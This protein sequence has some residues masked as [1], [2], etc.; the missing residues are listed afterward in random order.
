[1]PTQKPTVNPGLRVARVP[2]MMY[3]YVSI[4]PPD[5]DVYRLDLSV[6]PQAFDEQL[7][8][9]AYNG[10]RT[11]RASDLV[12]HLLYGAPLPE[13]PIVL[14]FD[15]GYADAY[16]AAF[17]LLKKYGM[18]ATF[19]VVTQYLESKK[20]G[21][22]T[23]AQLQEMANAG[24]E[25]GS[26]TAD[27]PDLRGKSIVFQNGQIAGSKQLIEMRLP[28]VTVKTFC[29][30]SG[31]YDA[32]TLAVLRMSGYLGAVTEIQGV[33]Q[34]SDDVYEMR[35]IRVRGSYSLNDYAYWLNWFINSGR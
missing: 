8:F 3:H 16:D 33:R 10:Y 25:I 13:K 2:I 22:A 34:T 15:D 27:H 31:K 7:A 29:Y 5:A 24:M 35:R 32:T 20:P 21:Y 18:V 9:L 17:P 6:S 11:I 1:M 30:P 12:E 26:H 19:F 14:T 4:P 28:G 23:W